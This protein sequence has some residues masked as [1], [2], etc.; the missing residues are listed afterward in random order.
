MKTR[1]ALATA[2]VLTLTSLT[3]WIPGAAASA[4]LPLGAFGAGIAPPVHHGTL[5]VAG[6]PRDGATVTATGLRWHA[7]RLP[8]G[9]SLLSFAVAY[10]WQSCD[11][12]GTH[13]RAGA[14]RTA[15][16]FAARRYAVGKADT[17]RRL[18]LTETAA[19]VVQ[20]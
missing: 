17:G 11:A 10:S 7:P 13:C 1:L 15:A 16:P 18:R 14:D 9:M 2:V 12:A 5:R 20:T 4:A 19:E 3:A 8:R 6:V